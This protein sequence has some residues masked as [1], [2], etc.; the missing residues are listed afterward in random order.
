MLGVTLFGIFLTPVFFYVIDW[1]SEQAIFGARLTR[2]LLVGTALTLGTI[3]I[4]AAEALIVIAAVDQVLSVEGAVAL[5]L[6]L[7]AVVALL[8]LVQRRRSGRPLSYQLPLFA[9]WPGRLKKAVDL[10]AGQESGRQIDDTTGA[11]RGAGAPTGAHRA[12]P[13]GRMPALSPDDG[14]G[15]EQPDTSAQPGD[16]AL[17]RT[18]TNSPQPDQG[19]GTAPPTNH[20]PPNE[21]DRPSPPMH[22]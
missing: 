13:T 11:I 20:D 8:I 3:A 7:L 12:V 9:L 22:E 16:A 15:Q 1:L 5:S 18:S 6:G 10:L 19:N 4:L 17:E 14:N 21:T 2:R